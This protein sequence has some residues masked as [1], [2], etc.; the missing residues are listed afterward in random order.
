MRK[1]H[2]QG[3]VP[4]TPLPKVLGVDD[5]SLP[6][7][8][9]G[10]PSLPEMARSAS[11]SVM[12]WARSGFQPTKPETLQARLEECQKCE[13]W[14]S[15]GFFNTGRCRKCGCSTQAKLRMATASCPVGKWGPEP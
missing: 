12:E 5:L 9:L 2:N 1:H 7:G 10:L 6:R 3:F 15:Q 11:T 13:F 8:P 4:A 14:D